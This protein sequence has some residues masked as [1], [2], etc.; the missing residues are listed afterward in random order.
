ME[1][2][3]LIVVNR[4]RHFETTPQTQRSPVSAA[5]RIEIQRERSARFRSEG[6]RL[7]RIPQLYQVHIISECKARK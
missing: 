4:M 6:S 7:T 3:I 5:L 1:T 2:Y